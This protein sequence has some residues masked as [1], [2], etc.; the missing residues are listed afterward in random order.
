MTNSRPGESPTP[1]ETA[2]D[3][4]EFETVPTSA[5]DIASAGRSCMAILMLLAVI[6]LVLGVWIVARSIG[7]G[8]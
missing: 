7:I 5:A 6:L 1:R 2:P 3:E 4:F 8:Q